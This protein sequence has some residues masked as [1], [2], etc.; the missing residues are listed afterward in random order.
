MLKNMPARVAP[1]FPDPRMLGVIVLAW[2]MLTNA[3]TAK[4]GLGILTGVTA[5]L[6]KSTGAGLVISAVL[7]AVAIFSPEFKRLLR[8]VP[9]TIHERMD[10]VEKEH[11]PSIKQTHIDIGKRI[12]GVDAHF[13][14]R[15][16]LLECNG[17]QK[18]DTKVAFS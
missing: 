6:A 15:C 14:K 7:I 12:D 8:Y 10:S 18:L 9:K 13:S 11:L 17:P 1:L 4:F 3:S 2:T 5:W 16:G